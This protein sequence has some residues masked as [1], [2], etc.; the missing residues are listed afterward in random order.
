MGCGGSSEKDNKGNEE[1]DESGHKLATAGAFDKDAPVDL[2]KNPNTYITGN[3][4]YY[5]NQDP[6]SG[7]FDD[8]KFPPNADSFFARTNGKPTDSNSDRYS[9]SLKAIKVN[10]SQV[11]WKRAKEIWGDDVKIF[12]DKVTLE[13]IKIGE[14]ADAYFVATL[15]ALAEFPAL[16]VQLFKTVQLP[17]DGS[18]IQ[19]AIQIDG[20]WKIVPID[21]R[22][23]VNKDTNK[24]IFSD[25]P[26]KCI[27]GVVLEKVWAKVNGGYA[28]IV[29]GFPREVFQAFT[30]FTTIPIEIAKENKTSLWNNIRDS[31]TYNCI[32]TCSIRDG[33]QGLEA[34]GLIANHS[35]SLV[36]A[37]ERE[38]NGKKLKL[39]KLRN[40]FGEGEWTGDYSD[41]SDKWTNDVKKAFPE[42]D[43]VARDD[44]IFWIDFD[45]FC[46]YFQI[47]SICVPLKPLISTTIKVPKDK[48]TNYNV[49]KLNVQG[50]GILSIS[51]CKKSY[52]FHRKI[53][54]EEECIENI[55]VAKVDKSNKKFVYLDSAYNETSSTAVEAGEYIVIYNVDYKTAGVKNVRKYGINIGSSVKFTCAECDPDNDLTLLKSI[56]IPKIE[57][58]PKYASRF[59]KEFVLFTGNR[60]EGSAI[61][62]FYLK[63]QADEVKHV[64]PSIY[65]KN[66]KSIEGELPKGL[67]MVKNSTFLYL[68]NRIKASLPFQTGGNAKFSD[69]AI[70]GA[71]EPKLDQKVIDKYLEDSEYSE[72]KINFEFMQA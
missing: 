40:P 17:T 67:K 6:G 39:M 5:K 36:S 34:V 55:I 35:F 44:G 54:P 30:P 9:K 19:V 8:K 53:A 13:D 27:W 7:E 32:M 72:P 48:A 60:F 12:G 18:A 69:T 37:F 24:P 21:D 47:V 50:S 3:T 51:V 62:F 42:F 61:G 57:S 10:D 43:G 14:V 49:L 16:I 4:N 2:S 41:N 38:V 45:N 23:P 58:L 71:V 66:E 46:K 56:M 64:K 33:T 65:L 20:D 63:N 11:E 28:N 25:A 1:I 59:Q 26:N 68:A 52:R 31:D 15:A 29:S 70:P 22:F